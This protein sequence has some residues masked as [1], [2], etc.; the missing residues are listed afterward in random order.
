MVNATYLQYWQRRRARRRPA[1]P[2]GDRGGLLPR[3]RRD[4]GRP[5][6][7]RRERA[8]SDDEYEFQRTY[9]EPF[10]YAPVTGCFSYYSQ[11][12]IE[13]SQNAVLSGDDSRLFVTRLV[14]LLS[15]AEP[16]GRQRP[17]DARPAP[18]RTRRTTG[19][20][21]SAPT[22]QAAV[23]ALEPSTGRILAMVSPP[24]LRP[25][26]AGL[27]RLRRGRATTTSGSTPTES[28]PLLNRAIQTTLPPGSTFKLVTAAAAHRE[29]QLRRPTRMVPG[30]A[31]YQLPQT[32]DATG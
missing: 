31:T 2:P 17:A 21:P 3:A 9:P 16:Q 20:G 29:R 8:E 28:Q 18:P 12:G 6:R 27:A 13:Q 32:S 25:Q 7:R 30:G 24:D 22:S 26:P 23:V 5:R 10:K 11:T 1:Q 15:N 19:C 14:D 4:P